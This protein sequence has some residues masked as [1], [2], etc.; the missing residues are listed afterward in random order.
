MASTTPV[1]DGETF[2]LET[3]PLIDATIRF[4]CRRHHCRPDEAEEFA[5]VARLRLIEDDYAVLRKFGGR[6]SLRTYL[7]VVL[8]RMFLDFRRQHWGVWRPS[9]EARRL[10]AI[11]V[12]L[13][14]LLHR[15]G[16]GLD[17]AIEILRTNERVAA[18]QAELATLAARLPRRGVRRR[19]GESAAAAAPILAEQVE[20]MAL[21]SEREEHARLLRGALCKVLGALEVEDALILRLRFRDD[22]TV[23]RIASVL[24]VE[25]KP[26]YRRLGRL[27]GDLRNALEKQGFRGS[28]LYDVLGSAAWDDEDAR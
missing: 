3:L 24:A 23:A 19:E 1:A 13:D 15:D 17:E 27:L 26:L 7:S 8:G 5:S 6:C 22:F 2:F 9:A 18:T 10:G 4:V 25:A 16:V 11:A 21:A 28:D 14:V 12:R 20:I